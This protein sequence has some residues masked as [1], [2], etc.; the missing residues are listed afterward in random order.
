MNNRKEG[1]LGED[2]AI[3][4]LQNKGYKILERN[5]S[6]KMG[7]IDIIAEK[8]GVIVFVEVKNR[9][10]NRYG[11]P[12]EAV[13]KEKQRKII[14]SANYY[15]VKKK[16]FDHALRFDV[17]SI[18]RD[19]MEHIEYAFDANTARFSSKFGY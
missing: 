3:K 5:Y 18:L 14:A 12:I 2:S 19:N 10:N 17:I 9:E 7:E 15:I 11:E 13:S 6:T 1:L 16:L 4:Y 8:D